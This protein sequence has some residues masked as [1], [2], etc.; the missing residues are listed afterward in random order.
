MG[1]PQG[2][3]VETLPSRKRVPWRLPALVLTLLL[4]GYL[5]WSSRPYCQVSGHYKGR[6][7]NEFAMEKFQ[8]VMTLVQTEA[9]LTGQCEISSQSRNRVI[10]HRARL[11]GQVQ[12][13]RFQ[14]S[15]LLDDG[16]MV[17]FSGSPKWT[18]DGTILFGETWTKAQGVSQRVGFRVDRLDCLISPQ[19]LSV[20]NPHP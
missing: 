20:R 16:R 12:A 2:Y 6:I 1:S 5:Y 4:G 19:D 8:L 7:G 15:G 18:S 9:Q 11:L 3:T 13:D 14:V 17:Y 10:L